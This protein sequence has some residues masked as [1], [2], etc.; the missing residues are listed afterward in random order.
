MA[1]NFER[2][3]RL[4]GF[5]EGIEKR[6][7]DNA[8]KGEKR[9]TPKAGPDEEHMASP[10]EWEANNRLHGQKEPE[11]QSSPDSGNSNGRRILSNSEA[12]VILH[13]TAN[14]HGERFEDLLHRLQTSNNTVL[15][16]TGAKLARDHEGNFV[17]YGYTGQDVAT[18]LRQAKEGTEGERNWSEMEQLK[19]KDGTLTEADLP[20]L[21][22]PDASQ[23]HLPK[24]I[25][26]GRSVGETVPKLLTKKTDRETYPEKRGRS[27]RKRQKTKPRV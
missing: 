24:A 16:G 21:E 6:A 10:K 27:N 15:T 22:H 25:G 17:L 7:V 11:E 20:H 12:M 13:Q 4:F 3:S 1:R 26:T 9:K 8:Q 14:H 19:V 23:D 2:M 5:K 18:E